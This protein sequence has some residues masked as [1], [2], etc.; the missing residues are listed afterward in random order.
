LHGLVNAG[1]FGL[2][3]WKTGVCRYARITREELEGMWSAMSV[4]KDLIIWEMETVISDWLEQ[5]DSENW[6]FA[7]RRYKMMDWP[8]GIEFRL[9]GSKAG[10]N[11]KEVRGKA[12]LHGLAN[13]ELGLLVVYEKSLIWQDPF[14]KADIERIQKE[15]ESK[16]VICFELER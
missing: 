13:A 3:V 10:I 9:P 2:L 15:M 14:K 6:I 7:T 1:K 12:A 4:K 8:D 16:N 11:W 5:Y